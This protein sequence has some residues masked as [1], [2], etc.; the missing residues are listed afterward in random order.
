[1]RFFIQK[2]VDICA[3]IKTFS[4]LNMKKQKERMLVVGKLQGLSE[5]Q[6]PSTLRTL[7]Y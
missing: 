1:M 7:L 6:E 3:T 2:Y 5:I 4:I